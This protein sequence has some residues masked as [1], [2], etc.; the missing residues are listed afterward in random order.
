M[1]RMGFLLLFL[2]AI[3]YPAEAQKSNTQLNTAAPAQVASAVRVY[4]Q[5]NEHAIMEKFTSLLS[6]P[7]TA[8][9]A[10]NIQKNATRIAAM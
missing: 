2:S 3:I 4:R 10:I 9:D 6:I 7:N 5:A 1:I 8:S